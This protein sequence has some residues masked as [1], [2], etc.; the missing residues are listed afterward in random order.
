M[1]KSLLFSPGTGN[2][3]NCH[4]PDGRG[5]LIDPVAGG[6]A[7]D[8]NASRS[9][10]N[11]CDTGQATTREDA[12]SAASLALIEAGLSIVDL[13]SADAI[14]RPEPKRWSEITEDQSF[15]DAGLLLK[16]T[17]IYIEFPEK[18][19]VDWLAAS[20][21]RNLAGLSLCEQPDQEKTDAIAGGVLAFPGATDEEIT[22]LMDS[23]RVGGNTVLRVSGEQAQMALAEVMNAAALDADDLESPSP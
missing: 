20:I 2:C 14:E 6:Q 11:S 12:I 9:W 16:K 5:I 21:S 13:P 17:L 15:K 1:K 22:E 3:W 23:L 8:W 7:W 18:V 10:W 4:T 19:N